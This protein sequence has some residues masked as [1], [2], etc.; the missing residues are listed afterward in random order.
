MILKIGTDDIEYQQ[1][2]NQ[3][4]ICL[5]DIVSK[6]I[7]SKNPKDYMYKIKN[8]QKINKKFYIPLH[9]MKEILEKSKKLKT[10]LLYYE[11]CKLENTSQ[12]N[13]TDEITTHYEESE[14]KDLEPLED[15]VED[16]KSFPSE[17]KDTFL[18][19]QNNYFK[20]KGKDVLIIV[21][22]G[23]AWFKGKDVD[24]LLEFNKPSDAILYNV[25]NND[26]I[27]FS[28]LGIQ[29]DVKIP[30]QDPQTIFINKKGIQSL[31]LR[32]RKPID[33]ELYEA[34]GIHPLNQKW[35][36]KEANYLNK[37]IKIFGKYHT[38]QLQYSIDNYKV[39][40]YFDK[41]NLVIECDEFGHSHY[42][43][44]NEKQRQLYIENKLKCK[45]IRFNPDV[46]NFDFT[47][48]ILQIYDYIKTLDTELI[49]LE[50]NLGEETFINIEGM[51]DL[52]MSS[53]KPEAKM[54]RRWLSHQV[55]PSLNKFGSFS[56]SKKYG[57]FYD[58]EDLFEYQNQNV[59]YVAYIGA[60]QNEPLFKFGISF[61][62]YRR[63]Y[64]EH[65]KT[66]STF[67]LIYLRRTD[68][69]RQI[70]DLFKKECHAKEIYRKL[71]IND[72]Q[73]TEIFTI[74]EIQTFDR[75]RVILDK[76][77]EHNPTKEIEKRDKKIQDLENEK[78]ILETKLQEK[79]ELVIELKKDKSWLQS[80][81][82]KLK[83]I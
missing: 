21:V 61:D 75:I 63:E 20:Y 47:D 17:L 78:Q 29:L 28:E 23:V 68:N 62:Y 6:I 51:Y 72:K 15:I 5:S 33:S 24:D 32:T 14:I 74:N 8:K 46:L 52:I 69:N 9:Q 10:R 66:F 55:L 82:D 19:I 35:I 77:I 42:D 41:L 12:K 11:L 79:E 80:L 36:C 81:L 25:S 57:N 13:N 44:E 40:L 18:D 30:K 31:F 4:W 56:L 22:N 7:E 60:P 1:L 39:D 45:F 48:I 70:E 43:D 37:L 38:Y 59:F 67:D 27:P 73:Y 34:F 26:K 58:T 83:I 54:F 76:L 71:E 53:R 65:K 50:E 49:E 16:T 2:D 3:L 64:K